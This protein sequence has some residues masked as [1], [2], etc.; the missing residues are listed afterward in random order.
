[1]VD[2]E[3]MAY[4]NG[5]YIEKV[6]GFLGFG[7]KPVSRYYVNPKLYYDQVLTPIRHLKLFPIDF[8]DVQSLENLESS[9]KDQIDER[10]K[11]D[12]ISLTNGTIILKENINIKVNFEDVSD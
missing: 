6:G 5:P 1:M 9:I 7:G 10:L 3:L 4:V 12:L 8:D 11:G 2:A